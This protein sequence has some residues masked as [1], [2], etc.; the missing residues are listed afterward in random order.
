MNFYK[1]DIK[2][3]DPTYTTSN[4]R[5]PG[6]KNQTCHTGGPLCLGN[7]LQGDHCSDPMIQN[8]ILPQIGL[9]HKKYLK[10][11]IQGDHC[12]WERHA[13][14]P[15][16][17]DPMI[18]NIVLPQIGLPQEKYI[19]HAIQGDHCVWETPFKE[20]TVF[21]SHDPKSYTTS[22]WLAPGQIFF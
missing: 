11:A 10:H 14:R 18:Q 2:D 12:V 20:T 9:P 19:K 1:G 22:D 16:C 3:L 8:I 13:G 17:S 21:R 15:L 7:A 6:Q 4:L 5:A